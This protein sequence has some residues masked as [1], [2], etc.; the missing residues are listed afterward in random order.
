MTGTKTITRTI[1]EAEYNAKHSADKSL[2]ELVSGIRRE[3][4]EY[5]KKEEIIREA[6][7][8]GRTGSAFFHC[9]IADNHSVR[10]I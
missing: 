2:A 4:A 5:V 1:T 3:A 6:R 9:E 10:G 8:T 7:R